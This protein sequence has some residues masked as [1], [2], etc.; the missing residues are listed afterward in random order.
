MNQTVLLVGGPFDGQLRHD[1]DPA[2]RILTIE[3][4]EELELDVWD[5]CVVYATKVGLASYRRVADCVFEHCR[6]PTAIGDQDL[7][8]PAE[9][10]R[11]EG[12]DEH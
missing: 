2:R 11:L 8:L 3:W 9:Q 1:V 4:E 6:T 12:N 10:L 5:G 7:E